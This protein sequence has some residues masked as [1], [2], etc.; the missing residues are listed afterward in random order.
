MVNRAVELKMPALAITDH[1]VMYGVI[2]FYKAAKEAGIKPVIGC[3]VYVAPRGRTDRDPRLDGRQYHL[4]LLAKNQ[5]GYQNLME[6]V[7]RG[8]SEGFYY[9]P[10]VDHELLSRFSS[11]LIALSAC[12]AGEVPQAVL[13]QRPERAL[14]LVHFYQGVFGENFYLELQDHGM[15]E[16]K[17]VNEALISLSRQTGVPLVATNDLHYIRR[18]DA[19]AHDVLLCIQTAKT[20]EDE[21]RMRFPSQEFY[22]K[23]DEEIGALFPLLPEVLENTLRIAESCNVDFEFGRTHLPV[24]EIPGKMDENSFL[25]KVCMEG[26]QQRYGPELPQEVA[27]RLEYEL[28]VISQMGF[29]SYFLIVWDFVRYAHQNGILVGPGRGSAAGS[30]VAY[31]LAIT[32]IDPLKYGLLFERFLNPERVSMPDIDIDFCYEKRERVIEYVVDKYG[33]ENVAQII[34]FGTMAARA[35]VRDVGRALN[36]PYAE[37]DRIAKMIPPEPNISIGEALEKSPDLM[38]LYKNE[39]QVKKLIDLSLAVE[40]MPRHAST[41]AAGVVISRERLVSYIPL[42]KSGEDGLVT[43]FPMNKLDE[44]GL[45]KMDFLGLRTLTMMEEVVRLVQESAG[46]T[47]D[48][49]R[50]PLDDAATYQLLAQGDTAGIFQLES[51]G[52]RSVLRELKP[53]VFEDIIAVVALYRPGPMEQIPTFIQSKH[54]NIPIKYLHP[55]LEPILRETYGVMVYQ[56][57]IMQVASSMAGFSLGEADL[58]RRA[59]GKKKLEILTEQR[60]RFVSGCL[61]NGHSKKMANELYD[62]IVKFASYGFNK[63]HAAAYAMIAYQTAYLKANFPTQF[64][65][66]LLTSAISSSDK[67]AGYIADCKRMGIHVLPPDINLSDANFTVGEGKIIRFGLAAVKNVGLGAI[68]SILS[69]RSEQGVFTS[70]RDFCSRV[71]LRS[72]NKKVLESLIKSGAMECLGADRNQLLTI[73]EESLATGQSLQRERQNGQMSMFELVEEDHEWVR[74]NDDLPQLNGITPRERLAMEKESLGLYISGHPLEEYDAILKR[75]PGLVRIADLSE[76]A[77]NLRVTVAGMVS[78]SKQIITKT[79]KPMSFFTLEDL[80]G[81]VEVVVFSNVYEKARFYLENDHV[82]IASGRTSLKEEEDSKIIAE[83]IMPLPKE[84]RELVIHCRENDN[85]GT[86]LSLKKILEGS[87]GTLPVY[88]SFAGHAGRVLL[89]QRYWVFEDSPLLAEIEKLFGCESVRFNKAG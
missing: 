30:L 12:I 64:M 47:I 45:L 50:L 54:G 63:S 61:T 66:G 8:Y 11:G 87:R 16:Q 78:A 72:C 76:L 40:G 68:E 31:C 74:V 24:Y 59:I 28:N 44:L 84:A 1:G 51:S 79:G 26:A 56:E 42:Q 81:S 18:D 88:L 37:V 49:S 60:E 75:F 19:V 62:L 38:A 3:E 77:D 34:T 39:E 71:D 46:R 82:L 21:N 57:Q 33:E 35:A 86:L 17:K 10:R 15:P 36:I 22:L 85:M 41:H 5:E 23:T 73:L 27:D 7:T 67:V 69:A 83:A 4:V 52:M 20:L 32:D 14:E 2:D 58:L 53:N 25:H 65:A 6:L 48:H 89:E 70:L 80:S 29:A 13:E 43:Q 55:Q 9:K